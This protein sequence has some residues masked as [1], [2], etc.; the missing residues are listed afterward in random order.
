MAGPLPGVLGPGPVRDGQPGRR[1]ARPG[2]DR[3]GHACPAPRR[4]HGDQRRRAG[5]SSSTSSTASTS[6]AS[7]TG[8]RRSSPPSS[9][10]PSRPSCGSWRSSAA[11]GR[12]GSAPPASPECL[13]LQMDALG[14]A[15]DRARLARAV[16]AEH[17]PALAR[18]HFSSIAAALGVTTRPGPAGPRAHPPAAAAVPGVRRQRAGGHLLRRP[19]RGRARGRRARRRLHRR[20]GGAGPAPAGHPRHHGRSRRGGPGRSSASSTTGG[21]PCGGW[22]S[23]PSSGSG[24]SWS[25]G[26]R[27]CGR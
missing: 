12:P 2:G 26:R 14:L 20:A 1:R 4:A 22:P 19:G 23:T 25:A 21:T 6:T 24:S 27:R 16:I 15:D 5:R 9:A 17:L 13:L 3:A 7:W 10:S 8:R 18:G 11:A